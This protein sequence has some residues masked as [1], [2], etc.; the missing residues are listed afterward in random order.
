MGYWGAHR[1]L[2]LQHYLGLDSFVKLGDEFE[3]HEFTDMDL[4]TDR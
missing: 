4:L 3:P 2:I 1:V